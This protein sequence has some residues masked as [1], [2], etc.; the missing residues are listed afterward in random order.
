MKTLS[1]RMSLV[2]LLVG[3]ALSGKTTALIAAEDERGAPTDRLERLER[4][5]NEL[6]QRQERMMKRLESALEREG[7]MAP[8]G[9]P[10]LRPPAPMPGGEGLAAPAPPLG[11]ERNPGLFAPVRPFAP[12]A[13]KA[14][15]DL[16]GLLKLCILG[17]IIFNI[18]LAIWIFTDIRKRGDGSGVFIALALVAGIPAAIIYTLVRIG[19][20]KA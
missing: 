15:Q 19:D 3:L 5:I 14:L 9:R 12:K 20:K 11:P 18:L 13:I 8:P 1:H 17:A 7:R 16:H 6:A 4:R 10:D 2:V